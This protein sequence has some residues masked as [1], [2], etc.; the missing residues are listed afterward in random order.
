MRKTVDP[1]ET[2]AERISIARKS[3]DTLNV[4]VFGDRVIIRSIDILPVNKI[5]KLFVPTEGDS[6]K[7]NDHRYQGIIV[8]LSP[9]AESK[10]LKLLDHIYGKANTINEVIHEGEVYLAIYL[11]DILCV[12]PN[13]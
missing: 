5:G 7:F 8:A 6:I 11:S 3:K 9:E 1:N 10:G 13:E 2:N 4:R 12:V